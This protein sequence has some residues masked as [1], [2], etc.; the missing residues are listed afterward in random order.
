V[1]L[2]DNV[3]FEAGSAGEGIRRRLLEQFD[4]HTMLR[5]PTGIFYK[6]GVKANVLFFE[7]RP[8]RADGVP[9]TKTLWIYDFRTNKNF[10]LKQN[11]LVASDLDDFVSCCGTNRA[12]RKESERFKRFDVAD[13]LKRDKL[14]LDITW[15][16]DESLDDIDNLLPPDEIAAELVESLQEALDAFQSVAEELKGR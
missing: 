12:K 8:P 11:P 6:P 15:L 2:P 3:L 9:N 10:T 7:K 13:L 5:L 16:K 14:N 4:F 1:V